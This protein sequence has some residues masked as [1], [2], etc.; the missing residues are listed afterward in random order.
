MNSFPLPRLR[1]TIWRKRRS[2]RGLLGG[3]VG[4][5]LLLGCADGQVTSSPRTSDLSTELAPSG[6][7]PYVIQPGDDVE[8]KFPL[9]PDL[10]ERQIVRPDGKISMQLVESEI[11]AAGLTIDQLRA[12]LRAAYVGQLRD[13]PIAV[14]IRSFGENRIFVGGEVGQTGAQPLNH[15]TTVRQAILQAQGFKDS[16]YPHQVI[17]YRQTPGHPASWQIL[18]LSE[19]PSATGGD[20]DVLL[21]P[22]DIVYVPRSSIADVGRFV[23][24]YIR[25]L[26]PVSPSILIQ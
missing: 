12:A 19:Y 4:C 2:V 17:L 15:P 7:Q 3:L 9:T 18:D 26:L 10:N 23:D 13:P 24:L 6:T 16:A 14:L 20:Q 25:R 11:T 8:V 1:R 22:L 5:L 21:A